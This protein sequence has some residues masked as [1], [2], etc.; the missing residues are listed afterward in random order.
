MA[1]VFKSY[2]DAIYNEEILDLETYE[3]FNPMIKK[4]K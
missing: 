2:I 3:F 4:E 1:N